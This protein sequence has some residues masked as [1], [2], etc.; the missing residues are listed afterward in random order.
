MFRPTLIYIIVLCAG[1]AVRLHAGSMDDDFDRMDKIDNNFFSDFSKKF[2][3]TAYT[4]INK[5]KKGYNGYRANPGLG[6]DARVFFAGPKNIFEFISVGV[7]YLPLASPEDVNTFSEDIYT[8]QAN[9][10]I[11]YSLLKDLYP[12]VG[13]G[14]GYYLHRLV[15]DDPVFGTNSKVQNYFG[16]NYFIGLEYRLFKFIGINPQ[17]KIHYIYQPGLQ[18]TI[19]V[20]SL[21][22]NYYFGKKRRKDE[23]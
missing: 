4:G 17:Y 11:N 10:G 19:E 15:Q 3:L 22:L 14:I 2:V 18:T 1:I 21:Q 23:K 8:I 7:E 5:P 16:H 9:Y 12:W 20:L 13:F 6:F